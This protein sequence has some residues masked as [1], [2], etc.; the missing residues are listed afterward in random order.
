MQIAGR[1]E[2]PAPQSD[3][4]RQRLREVREKV[5][6]EFPPRDQ[7]LLQP[8]T[9]GIGAQIRAAREAQGLTWNSLAQKAGIPNA[10]I[11][12]DLEFGREVTSQTSRQSS[13]PSG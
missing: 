8:V 1:I 4:E 2:S 12:R 11:V 7:P 3:E 10:S 13:P 6:E 9:V 5:K